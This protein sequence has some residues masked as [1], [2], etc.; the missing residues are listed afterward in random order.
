MGPQI[1]IANY[2]RDWPVAQSNCFARLARPAVRCRNPGTGDA[3]TFSLDRQSS[4]AHLT[5][6]L[7]YLLV[8][9]LHSN[10]KCT[11]HYYR[12]E[13]RKPARMSSLADVAGWRPRFSYFLLRKILNQFRL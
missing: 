5:G 12:I 1:L 7:F 10:K 8:K 3:C 2:R 6:A 9:K 4:R 11:L 13:V